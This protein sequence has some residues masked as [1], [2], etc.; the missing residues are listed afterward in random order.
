[1]VEMAL[2]AGLC[3]MRAV[4]GTT[5]ALKLALEQRGPGRK[6]LGFPGDAPP[7]RLSRRCPHGLAPAQSYN[8]KRHRE[9]V[10]PL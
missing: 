8:Q 4:G 2:V 5:I 10:R 3:E 7:S 9:A 1:M 6:Y